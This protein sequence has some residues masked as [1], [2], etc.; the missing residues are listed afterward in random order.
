MVGR[1]W[2]LSA[3]D[4]PR[5]VL[6]ASGEVRYASSLYRLRPLASMLLVSFALSLLAGVWVNLSSLFFP[7]PLLAPVLL[8]LSLVFALIAVPTVI[9]WRVAV[10]PTSVRASYLFSSRAIPCASVRS[11]RIAGD[12]PL[13]RIVFGRGVSHS[14]I[15]EHITPR[16][17]RRT[18][19]L[20]VDRRIL[21]ALHEVLSDCEWRED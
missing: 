7:T 9:P 16:G 17:A 19:S 18:T 3:S 11:V 6:T 2:D 8:G 21:E 14:L 13:D 1:E 20:T 4:L 15:L 12:G 10:G 5:P